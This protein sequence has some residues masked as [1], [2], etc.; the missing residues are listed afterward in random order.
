M[1]NPYRE[2]D[3]DALH[4]ELDGDAPVPTNV[5]S[6]ISY[7]KTRKLLECAG[8]PAALMIGSLQPW[9]DGHRGLF[10][11]ALEMEGY[12]VIGVSET[13]GLG[14]NNPFPFAELKAR[15][16]ESLSDFFGSFEIRRLP[17]I[18]NVVYGPLAT[19]KN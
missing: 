12:V 10:M 13:Y 1:T 7:L 17:N 18:T 15:I 4:L 14:G 16:E 5:E 3:P 2:P 19:L 11:Q 9:Y 6:I 8:K